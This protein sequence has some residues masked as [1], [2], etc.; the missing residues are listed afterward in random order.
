M[1]QDNK[2]IAREILVLPSLINNKNISIKI[3]T[4]ENRN[5]PETIYIYIS[6]WI[7]PINDSSKKNL[8]DILKKIYNVQLKNILT[9]NKF[10]PN[11]QENIYICNVPESFNY[12]DKNNFISLELYLHTININS[13]KKYPLNNKKETELFR[14]ALEIANIMG[15]SLLLQS[16]KRFEI[17]KK[18]TT[19]ICYS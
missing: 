11:I 1:I 3:G 15:D 9:N 14:N 7:K 18:S 4:V 16:K 6:F 17:H 19:S 8:D 5:Y 2:R 12:N 13:E 10:F